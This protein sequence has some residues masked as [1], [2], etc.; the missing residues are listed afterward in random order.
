MTTFKM[1]AKE[2]VYTLSDGETKLQLHEFEGK[3]R[4][5]I[6]KFKDNTPTHTG[7]CLYEREIL[8]FL[9]IKFDIDRTFEER[10]EWIYKFN[11]YI[12]VTCYKNGYVDFRYA[13][14]RPDGHVIY[15]K[16]GITLKRQLLLEIYEIL[17][18][19]YVMTHYY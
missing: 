12:T 10:N 13:F 8:H 9:D 16:K 6:R 5:H 17:Y 7:V 2:F 1:A 3:R 18:K 4:L 14:R 19:E 11:D 15:S